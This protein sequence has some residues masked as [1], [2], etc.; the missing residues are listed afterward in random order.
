MRILFMG[1]PDFAVSALKAL[2]DAGHD[3]VGVVSQPDKPQGRKMVLTPPPVKVFAQERGISVYQPKSLKD[4]ALLPVLEALCPELIVVV[5]YGKLLP[6]YVLSFPKHGC[7][8]VH[9]SLLP[10]Y[11]GAAP[12]V[13]AIVNGE[14]ETGVTTMQMDAGL[15]TGD[16]LVVKKTK[17]DDGDT[18]ET[19]TRRLAALGGEALLETICQMQAVTLLPAAQDEAKQTYAPILTKEMGR[20]DWSRSAREVFNQ[21]RGMNT[22]PVAY[23]TIE[24]KKFKI[25]SCRETEG[26]GVPG[27]VLSAGPEGFVV[28]CGEKS[29][30][31][32]EFQFDGKKRTNAKA[33]FLGNRIAPGAVCQ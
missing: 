25:F 1:T 19:L 8:N 29:V 31:I 22:W 18:A 2:V 32:L 27:K 24:G 26:V 20:V 4:G 9:A 11:R 30:E 17:I 23:S 14:T 33:Y 12:I 13:W 16:M 21:V 3:V 28:A 10:K 5:A 15:D 7:V 6:G